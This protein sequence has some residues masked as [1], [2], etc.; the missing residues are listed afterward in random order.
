MVER[1]H[2]SLK[3]A[4]MA[5]C[6]DDNWKVQL[7]WVL[8]GLRTTP[9]TNGDESPTQKVYGKPLAPRRPGF[10][11]VRLHQDRR[12]PL[13]RPY[14]GL[15]HVVSRASKAYLTNIHGRED[16]VSVDRLKPALLM[17]SGTQEETGRRPRIP[18]QNK[19]WM[20]PSASRNVVEDVPRA[21]LSN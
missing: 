15:Y 12:P 13:T 9:R 20:N 18:P 16:W 4:L 5:R 8:L 6:T 3:A 7:P 2:R 10:L 21:A 11:H 14:R 17:G 19:A 1:T